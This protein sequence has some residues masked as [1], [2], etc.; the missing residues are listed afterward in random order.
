MGVPEPI[1]ELRPHILFKILEKITDRLWEIGGA[2][3]IA[4][5]AWL[6]S[7][8]RSDLDYVSIA[9]IFCAAVVM[10]YLSTKKSA[11]I[12]RAVTDPLPPP[13]QP[14]NPSTIDLP[15]AQLKEMQP[16]RDMFPVTQ[17]PEGW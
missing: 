13:V 10:M 8:L 15:P 17:R 4:T 5:V 6:I 3:V 9:V 16:T 12:S 7:K 14:D 11:I 2:M 1:R